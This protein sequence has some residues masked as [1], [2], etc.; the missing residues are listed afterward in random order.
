[1]IVTLS[2]LVVEENSVCLYGVDMQT[3]ADVKIDGRRVL[4][5]TSFVIIFT[6]QEK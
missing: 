4:N 2:C 6:A 5:H 1:M 3:K